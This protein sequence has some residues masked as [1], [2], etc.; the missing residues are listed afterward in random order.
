VT[1]LVEV[2]ARMVAAD[3]GRPVITQYEGESRVEL[4]GATLQNWVAKVARAALLL[5]PR[6]Q[7]AA[8]MVG[9]WAAGWPIAH[10]PRGAAPERAEVV[11]ASPDRLE[12]A[13]R[14]GADEVLAVSLDPLGAPL[15]ERPPG[16]LDF[17]TTVRG[18]GD[19]FTPQTPVTAATPALVGAVGP[20]GAVTHG[21]LIDLA[22]GRAAE[23]GL[24]AGGCLLVPLVEGRPVRPLDWLLAPL[25]VGARIVLSQETETA[26]IA[27]REKA[28]YVLGEGRA[29]E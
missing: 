9:C 19:R 17:T 18:H 10:G 16:V 6:W 1:H 22:R 3:P 8:I 11:F 15:P 20:R 7:T 12:V 14:L 27:E 28:T 25:A 21:D 26:V 23:W 5:P 13:Q 29:A 4:S 2:F 24:D